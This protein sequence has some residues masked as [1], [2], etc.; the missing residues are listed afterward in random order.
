[1]AFATAADLAARLGSA[2]PTGTVLAQWNAALDDATEYLRS[3]IGW[4]VAPAA[5]VEI[6]VYGDGRTS[7]ALPATAVVSAVAGDGAPTAWE[8]TGNVLRATSGAFCGPLTVTATLG[9]ETAPGDLKAW[10]CVLASSRVAAVRDL[11][12][13]SAAGVAAVSIDDFRKSW[14]QGETG[15]ELPQ[16]QCEQLRGRYGQTVY[17]TS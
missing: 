7:L 5:L 9:Y 3:V 2:V 16:R 15:I 17:V 11:G 1:M 14:S 12:S 6:P 4:H 13:L 8:Q 10:A